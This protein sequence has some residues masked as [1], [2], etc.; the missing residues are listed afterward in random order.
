[1]ANSRRLLLDTNAFLWA[2][3]QQRSLSSAAT[4][5]LGDESATLYVSLASV[6]EMQ[7]KHS[8]GKLPLS[9]P[10]GILARRFAATLEASLL[11]I[12]LD[13]IEQLYKLPNVHR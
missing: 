5:A 4:S 6:W 3:D 12:T 13:H 1:M 11:D 2:V 9:Q 7:I 8:L 10:A